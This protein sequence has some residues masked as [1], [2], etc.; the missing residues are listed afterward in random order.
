MPSTNPIE[1]G[2]KSA[3]HAAFAFEQ[4]SAF[5]DIRLGSQGVEQIVDYRGRGFERVEVGIVAITIAA[6][7]PARAIATPS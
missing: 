4:L 5:L 6:I 3:D 7:A 1:R 2:C